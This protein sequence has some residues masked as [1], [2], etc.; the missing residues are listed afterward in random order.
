MKTTILF[1]TALLVLGAVAASAA[2]P[3]KK[4]SKKDDKVDAPT[5]LKKFDTDFDTK[6]DK[7]E[8]SAALRSLK[9]NIF[10]TKSGALEKFDEDGDKK[11]DVN[12]LAKLLEAE[13][14][15]GADAGKPKK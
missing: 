10:S 3:P 9:T 13:P 2:P 1:S 8:L 14:K 12:E 5:M 4:G 7:A 15:P 6:L 11:L